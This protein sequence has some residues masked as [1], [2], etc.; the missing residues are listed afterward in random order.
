[1]VRHMCLGEGERRESLVL[2]YLCLC[3]FAQAFMDEFQ[4]KSIIISEGLFALQST[5]ECLCVCVFNNK[6]DEKLNLFV[7]VFHFAFG[8]MTFV[9]TNKFSC[10]LHTTSFYDTTND[11]EQ[12]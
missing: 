7:I 9:F 8:K 12:I 6:H 3:L 10:F 4:V 1:M 5:C 2:F 11:R